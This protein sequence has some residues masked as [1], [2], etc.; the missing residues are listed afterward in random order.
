MT[1]QMQGMRRRPRP[2][3]TRYNLH[4]LFVESPITLQA[5]PGRRA[6]LAAH[7]WA[8]YHKKRVV[9]R[10]SITGETRVWLVG[11]RE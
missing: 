9:T 10:T 7:K 8:G 11:D 6:V 1:Q 2:Y 4:R 5:E 3:P